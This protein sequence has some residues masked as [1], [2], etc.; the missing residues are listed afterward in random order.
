MRWLLLVRLINKK[1]PSAEEESI[2]IMEVNFLARLRNLI[3]R[4]ITR[5]GYLIFSLL[6]LIV[7]LSLSCVAVFLYNNYY[8]YIINDK[9]DKSKI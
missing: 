5:V 4:T 6:N 8:N 2:Y 3:R 9:N 7:H 1:T